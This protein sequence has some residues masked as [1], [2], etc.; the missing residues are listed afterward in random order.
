MTRQEKKEE[1]IGLFCT[2]AIFIGDLIDECFDFGQQHP[3]WISV[4]D[5]TKDELPPL[6]DK[7][8]PY[9]ESV[10]VLFVVEL[11]GVQYINKGTFDYDTGVWH[12][13]DMQCSFFKENVTHWM[14]LPE[15]PICDKTGNA[16][17][18]GT[19]EHIKVALDVLDKKGGEK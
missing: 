18:I 5:Y 14:P 13:L 8:N 15:L 19:E 7:N 17:I 10:H 3:D 4:E 1:L 6:I 16:H 9:G 12:S 2:G 11:D